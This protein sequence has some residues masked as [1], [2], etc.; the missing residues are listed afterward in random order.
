M[1]ALAP[2]H[3]LGHCHLIRSSDIVQ[4]NL[5]QMPPSGGWEPA[6][7]DSQF[8]FS[9]AAARRSRLKTAKGNHETEGLSFHE[10]VYQ[11]H[12]AYLYGQVETWQAKSAITICGSRLS[13]F[14][15]AEVF[16]G[17]HSH[18]LASLWLA[19]FLSSLMLIRHNS[20]RI[21][22]SFESHTGRWTRSL[23]PGSVEYRQC[24]AT[25]HRSRQRREHGSAA[26]PFIRVA[27]S[28]PATFAGGRI[29]FATPAETS[30]RR[31]Y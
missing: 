20:L 8:F 2:T 5:F 18:I 28:F 27:E 12:D 3:G 30:T 24:K 31:Q 19:V 14:S 4:T 7:W 15:R 13:T 29:S 10:N 17:Q 23:H 25:L 16:D 1:Q 9:C 22:R 11:K 26:D 6:R 21:N